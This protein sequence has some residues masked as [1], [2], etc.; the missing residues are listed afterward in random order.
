MNN[1]KQVGYILTVNELK[2]MLNGEILIKEGV[3]IYIDKTKPKLS[4]Y[5]TKIKKED[6]KNG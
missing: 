4:D 6:L 5:T 1:K 2:L 3:A